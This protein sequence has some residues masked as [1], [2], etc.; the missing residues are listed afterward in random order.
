MLYLLHSYILIYKYIGITISSEET[1]GSVQTLTFLADIVVSTITCADVL[2][3]ASEEKIG[4]DAVCSIPDSK[5]LKIFYGSGYLEGAASLQLEGILG[6]SGTFNRAVLPQFTLEGTT[7]D[8]EYQDFVNTWRV[9]PNG[10][11]QLKYGWTYSQGALSVHPVLPADG[12]IFEFKYWEA[13]PGETYSITV[14]QTDPANPQFFYSE[15]SL[16]F[17]VLSSCSTDGC[18]KVVWTLSN[19]PG[20]VPL[21]CTG[22]AAFGCTGTVVY[23]YEIATEY[24]P[25]SVGDMSLRLKATYFSASTPLFAEF[26]HVVL[27]GSSLLFPSVQVDKNCQSVQSAGAEF[28]MSA[29]VTD[30]GLVLDQDYFLE[31]EEPHNGGIQFCTTNTLNPRCIVPAAE[32]S[33]I[34]DSSYT[35]TL[36]LFLMCDIEDLAWDTV[37]FNSFIYS[38]NI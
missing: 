32:Q 12:I 13:T 16:P 29:I 19:D 33:L 22:D 37:T 23:P 25:G 34:P 6:T 30:N 4:R 35:Y 36:K 3:D 8:D 31:W 28:T 20:P 1:I 38:G 14:N 2:Q 5:T 26:T 17:T 15:T 21:D 7:T 27:C 18:R 11:G 9:T 10:S 24:Q